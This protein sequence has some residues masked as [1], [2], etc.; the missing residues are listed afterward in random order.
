MER[1]IALVGFMGCGKSTVGKVL[2]NRLNAQFLDTDTQ[3]QN[4]MQMSI[5]EIFAKYGEAYFRR[6]ERNLCKLIAVNQPLIIATGGGIIKGRCNIDALKVNG[7]IIYIKSSPGKI[8]SNIKNDN[9]RPLLNGAADKLKRIEELLE[10]RIPLYEECA[11]IIIDS[12]DYQIEDT[13]N[14]IIK[15]MG[16]LYDS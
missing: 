2:A 7:T 11:D 15:V 13:V 16:D 14:E 12:T 1:N 3:I 8:Y 10:E 4:D 9:T 6:L 5:N